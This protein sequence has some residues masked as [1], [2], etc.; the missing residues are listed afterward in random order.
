MVCWWTSCANARAIG[1][2]ALE[3]NDEALER[4]LLLGVAHYMGV[5]EGLMAVSGYDYFEE[6]LGTRGIF[7]RLL[8]GIRLIRA[9]EGRH[10]THGME[11]LRTKIAQRP[12][13]ASDVQRLFFEEGGKIPAR[14][15]FAFEPNDFQLDQNQMLAIAYEHLAQRSREAGLNS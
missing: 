8:E 1:R 10:L 14:T 4:A 6:M 15:Q 13:F 3:E 11:Y 5:V 9:D 7:P 2:A 12:E